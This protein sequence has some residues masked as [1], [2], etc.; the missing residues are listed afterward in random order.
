MFNVQSQQYFPVVFHMIKRRFYYKGQ[1]K[2]STVKEYYEKFKNNIEVM[3]QLRIPLGSDHG[4]VD[5]ILTESV[6][7]RAVP[8]P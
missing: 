4:M 3:E 1:E 7:S 6:Q 5:H 2:G 8:Q